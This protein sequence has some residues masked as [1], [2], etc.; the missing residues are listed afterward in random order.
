MQAVSGQVYANVTA[1][2]K[3][4]SGP[5]AAGTRPYLCARAGSAERWARL[6][7]KLPGR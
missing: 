6:K 3:A 5:D 1:I 2:M 4:P 7:R